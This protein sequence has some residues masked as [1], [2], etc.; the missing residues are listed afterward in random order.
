[1]MLDWEGGDMATCCALEPGAG[2]T[3]SVGTCT[4]LWWPGRW[5][6][7]LCGRGVQRVIE[8]TRVVSLWW[9]WRRR[10]MRVGIVVVAVAVGHVRR[11]RRRRGA[12]AG[13]AG[14]GGGSGPHAS[15]SSSSR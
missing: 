15:V 8:R 13:G 3:P 5:S 12:G 11:Y 1:M 4:H 14:G 6:V 7:P 9:R 2:Q 10:S